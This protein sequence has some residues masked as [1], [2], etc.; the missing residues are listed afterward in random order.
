MIGIL[1]YL[2]IF[3]LS[4]TAYAKEL[5]HNDLTEHTLAHWIDPPVHPVLNIYMFNLTNPDEFLQGAKPRYDEIGPYVF[6]DKWEKD[7][8]Q[9]KN[10]DDSIEYSQLRYFK[11]K[12]GPSKG[13]LRDEIIIPNIPMIT[14][15]NS[16]KN[17]SP[18]V[19]R[20]LGSIFNVLKQDKFIKSTVRKILFGLDNPL[21]KLG[22]DV[23]PEDK[24]YP[25][26]LFGLFVGRNATD[27]G[28][29]EVK[30]GLKNR[31]ELGKIVKIDKKS[32]LKWWFGDKCNEVKGTDGFIYKPNVKKSDVLHV[33]NR[34]LCRSIPLV[35]EKDIVDKNGIPGYRYVQTHIHM[36]KIT[37][38]VC[39]N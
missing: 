37:K 25:F 33:F 36:L 8:V 7:N 1:C 19:K 4:S 17:G 39:P 30:T 16:M 21:I 15:L 5:D 22:N 28:T 11:F 2:Y 32:K 29:T 38:I 6:T 27:R 12:P 9:W 26:P 35:F 20:A 23:L 31:D 10:G 14:A 18:L 3:A 34:D 24:K 13:Q